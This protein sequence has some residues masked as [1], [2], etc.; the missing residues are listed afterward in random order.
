ME[1]S[2][3]VESMVSYAKNVPNLANDIFRSF[4][5]TK[6]D[7]IDYDT[8]VKGE[9]ANSKTPSIHYRIPY[10]SHADTHKHT[11]MHPPI[12]SESDKHVL[13]GLIFLSQE[14]LSHTIVAGGYGIWTLVS[15]LS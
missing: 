5:S 7:G 14:L 1:H 11:V 9:Q 15:F 6:M 12:E 13:F 4:F 10:F 8:L 2:A 3:K